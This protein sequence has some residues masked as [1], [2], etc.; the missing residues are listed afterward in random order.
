MPPK[1]AKYLQDMLD[2]ADR[3]VFYVKDKDLRS[4]LADQGARDAVAWNFAVIGEALSQLN[5]MDASTAQLISE[6]DRIIA[7]RNQLIHGYSLVS[8]RIAWR[9]IH[10]KLPILQRELNALLQ[11]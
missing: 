10:D 6:W 9:I 1:S 5:K 3:I 4:F 8:Y 2:C 7:F 11:S